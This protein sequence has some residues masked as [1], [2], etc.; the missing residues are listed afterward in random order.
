MNKEKSM[1]VGYARVSTQDQNLD[2]QVDDL[3]KFGC[4]R[5][6]T[7]KLSGATQ[8]R[9]GL[10]EAMDFARLGDTLAVW[11]LDRL[12]R[13]LQHLIQTVNTLH[14]KGVGFASLTEGIDT[15]TPNG[16]L[17]FHVFG[18][19]AEFERSLIRERTVAGLAAARARGRI[20]GRPS[21]MTGEQVAM[22][23]TILASA[24][25][26]IPEVCKLLGVSRST[27]YRHLGL[28]A[29]NVVQANM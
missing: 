25:G 5:I 1:K 3:K 4:E 18:A 13:S 14:E 8:D 11:R 2:L 22:A 10:N 12:G 7:D 9:P 20:G 28:T 27:I 17:I 15:S 16:K 21:K 6:F 24:T 29:T 23:R 26:K 19:M